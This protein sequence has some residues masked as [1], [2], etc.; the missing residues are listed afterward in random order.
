MKH[1]SRAGLVA[2]L[3]AFGLLAAAPAG[4]AGPA[5]VHLR[6]EGDARTLVPRTALTTTTA[7]VVK[8]GDA[9]HGCPGTTV[10]GALEQGAAGDWSGPWFSG[11]GYSIDTIKGETHDFTDSY[12]NVWINYAY[13]NSGACQTELQEGDDV[14]ILSNCYGCSTLRGPLRVVAPATAQPGADFEVRVREYP[15]ALD[16]NYEGH[17]AEQASAGATVT[18]NGQTKTTDAAGVVR[19]PAG[20]SG[21]VTSVQATKPGFVRSATESVCSTTGGDGACGSPPC[22]TSGSDGRCGTADTEAPRA[23]I[24]GIFDGKHFTRRNAPR[25][26]RGSVTPDPTGLRAVK[27]RLTRQV[28]GR[29]WKYS[30]RRERFQ[31]RGCGTRSWFAIGDRQDWSYLLPARLGRGRYVLDVSALDKAGNRD[32]LVRGRTRVVFRVA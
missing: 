27:L 1:R 21:T 6:V 8:D 4:A 5:N 12:W 30:G 22:A 29:C 15:A 26:L 11:L 16:A 24:V 25:T 23:T 7:P 2:G 17:A 19:V 20:V 31:A 9:A 28:G 13:A 14:L 18:V 32:A 3:V 10:I